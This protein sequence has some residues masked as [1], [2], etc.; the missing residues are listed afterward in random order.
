[1]QLAERRTRV[2]LGL[3]EA[4]RRL[5]R[6]LTTLAMLA[7]RANRRIPERLIVAPTDLRAVDPFIAEEILAGRFPL[8]GRLLEAG[9]ESPFLQ[10]LPS[11]A[12]AG[13]LH[14]FAWLRHM[15]ALKTAQAR[16]Q[17]RSIMAS[18]L[19]IHGRKASGTG[20]EPQ[21]AAERLIAWLS[22]SPVVLTGAE[23]GF[24]RRFMK[25]LAFH[26]R[27]LRKILSCVGDADT[28]L[29]V[30]IAL[31]MASLAIPSSPR[32]VAREGQ[33]L[34]RELEQQ[35]LTDGG[36]ISR[37]PRAAL[38][39]L[40]D[41]LPLRQTYINL[42]QDVPAKLIPAIDRIFPALRFFRHQDGDL[43]LFNGATATPAAELMAV[44]RYDETGGKPFKALPHSQYHRL[45]AGETT[46]LVDTGKPQRPELSQTAHAGCLSFEFSA[47][48]S[49]LIVNAGM[50]KF[51]SRSYRLMARSTAAHSTVTLGETSSSRILQSSLLGPLMLD[52]IDN[53]TTERWEDAYG[54]DWLKASH[55][56][57]VAPFGWVHQ[58]EIGLSAKGNK[59]KGHDHFVIPGENGEQTDAKPV[60]ATARFHIHPSVLLTRVHD[61]TV[62]LEASDGEIW[63]FCA[64]GQPVQIEEDVFFADVSGIC[65]SQQ[66]V[67]EFNL[68]DTADLRWMLKKQG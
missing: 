64:P 38:E 25:S 3:T 9:G 12:F 20:W 59:I 10:A 35:I 32:V 36:H 47:G 7:G 22:H 62:S 28:R 48:R 56:G 24:Y 58:R 13:R 54:N 67:V 26:Q 41:L 37:N 33:R 21:V 39:V 29:K 53:V 55:D 49:R 61:D 18:W 31:A 30:H 15:R 5:C 46:I 8:A 17:A 51:A 65:S 42:G 45:T 4:R 57:Y 40:L 43:A 6:K 44:L 19:A 60:Q 1:M 52:G 63:Y 50:P 68:P 23:A 16:N 27:F 66:L 2:S 11:K 34:D 14:S